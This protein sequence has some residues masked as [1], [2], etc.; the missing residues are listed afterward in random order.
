MFSCQTGVVARGTDA[1]ETSR[2]MASKGET[3]TCPATVLVAVAAT[4]LNALGGGREPRVESHLQ[5]CETRVKSYQMDKQA[6]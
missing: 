5:R 3:P 2:D 4:D 1:D 6:C